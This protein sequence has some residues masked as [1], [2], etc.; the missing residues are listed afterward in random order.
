MEAEVVTVAKTAGHEILFTPLYSSNLQPI[1][2]LWALIKGN[3]GP[4]YSLGVTL[5]DFEIKLEKEFDSIDSH[6]GES[7]IN[8][9]T[10]AVDK[11]I[12]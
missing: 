8:S 7:S 2:L 5:N 10:E 4:S 11:K 12:E 3:I 6:D 1:E 9:M